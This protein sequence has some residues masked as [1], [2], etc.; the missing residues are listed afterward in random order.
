VLFVADPRVDV[1][2]S[3]ALA[4]ALSG[5]AAGGR[6]VALL[7]VLSPA[8][9]AR[10]PGIAP[11]LARLLAG[12]RVRLFATGAPARVGLALAWHLA[13][14]LAETDRRPRLRCETAILR[15]DRPWSGERALRIARPR[16]I[17]R[18]AAE[19]FGRP[20][21]LA[22]GRADVDP[23]AFGAGPGDVADGL[24]LDPPDAAGWAARLEARGLLPAPR[25]ALLSGRSL[26]APARLLMLSPNGI[27]LGHVA[28]LLAV[29]RRLPPFVEPVFLG[30]SRAIDLVGRF[31]FH[32][33]YLP[34]PLSPGVDPGRWREEF[35]R[36]LV[37][38]AGFHDAR[39]IVFDGNFPYQG[40][41]VARE[42]L[43]ER[44]FVWIRR[45]LWRAGSGEAALARRRLFD[46][47][48]EPADLA[49]EL[50]AG[51]TAELRD[52]H[53]VPPVTLL[54]P[55][56]LLPR[57]AARAALD[58]PPE[59]LTV[60]VQLGAGSN[61]DTRPVRRVVRDWCAGR[62]EVHVREV[63]WLIGDAG[64]PPEPPPVRR[65]RRLSGFPTAR[66]LAAFDFAVAIAGYNGF[67]EL[68]AAGVPTV[69]VPNDHPVMDEQE[70]RAVFAGRRGWGLHVPA[71]DGPRLWRALERMAD[72]GLRAHMR[73][74]LGGLSFANGARE[75]AALLA[76]LAAAPHAR[77][78]TPRIPRHPADW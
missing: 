73:A 31:G 58:I 21:L 71:G 36:R 41:E 3:E 53:R 43:P 2:E 70:A 1:E 7:P 22:A 45:G 35:P 19:F 63:E 30:M 40:F 34:G 78:D 76:L 69:F 25:G 16:E 46:L 75:I 4:G 77:R 67:H 56:E 49:A 72:A 37:E 59:A 24:R 11:P 65:I 12:G 33:E 26:I 28:R 27:G 14:F 62:P 50:D 20:P 42:M 10:R 48:I 54:E 60:L 44:P 15:L 51:D 66:F 39:A 6:S 74:R 23:C 38:A 55:D 32:H 13:P 18:R 47:V 5:F 61:F 17:L 57:E 52:A 9:G 29:A 8:H 64:K 68:M